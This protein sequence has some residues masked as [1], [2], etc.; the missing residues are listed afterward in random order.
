MEI[1]SGTLLL[2]FFLQMQPY[3]FGMFRFYKT[4]K[5]SVLM[6]QLGLGKEWEQAW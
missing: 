3:T 5:L 1:S 2:K 6:A 4:S